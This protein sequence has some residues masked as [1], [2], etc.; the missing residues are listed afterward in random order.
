MLCDGF[1]DSRGRVGRAP[2]LDRVSRSELRGPRHPAAARRAGRSRLREVLRRQALQ[3]QDR[4]ARAGRRA[5]VPAIRR[6]PR[7]VEARPPRPLGQGG[8]DSRRRALRAWD[9][10]AHPDRNPRRQLHPDGRGQ[11]LLHHHGC[12][13]RAR[14]RH[15]PPKDDGRPRSCPHPRPHRRPPHRDG[16]RQARRRGRN[17]TSRPR[18]ECYPDRQSPR[19]CPA[20]RS[21]GTPPSSPHPIRTDRRPSRHRWRCFCTGWTGY[22][23]T[24]H[25]PAQ[26]CTSSH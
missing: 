24:P 25:T 14:T 16:P 13:R 6:H 11:V 3:P 17:R 7:G 12:V 15:D 2:E 4:S 21:T 26:S 20:R 1:W 22:P 18:R 19:G 8:P 9:R 5:G 23:S 10:T